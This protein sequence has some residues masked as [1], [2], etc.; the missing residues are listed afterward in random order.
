VVD[1][2][3]MTAEYACPDASRYVWGQSRSVVAS[4]SLAG[5]SRITS[6]G[7]DDDD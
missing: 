5:D 3:I 4:R 7:K 1:D 2:I 6:P